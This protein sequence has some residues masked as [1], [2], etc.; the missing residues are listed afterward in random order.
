MG[1]AD[2]GLNFRRFCKKNKRIIIFSIIVLAVII[3]LNKLSLQKMNMP[4]IEFTYKPH[5]STMDN[6]SKVPSR[7]QKSIE[8]LV[9]EYVKNC[10]DRNYEKAFN[11][12]SEDCRNIH[13]NNNPNDFIKY[14]S[15]KM[16]TNK[17]YVIQNYSNVKIGN[18]TVYVYEI[19]YTEDLLATGLNGK[20]FYFTSEKLTFYKDNF[21]NVLMGVGGYIYNTEIKNIF[22]NEYLKIDIIKKIVNYDS[23]KYEIK[24]TNRSEKNIV[25]SS[26]LDNSEIVLELS[27]EAREKSEEKAIVLGPKESRT[28]YISFTKYV[29]D[30]DLS[31]NLNFNNIKVIE[32][33]LELSQDEESLEKVLNKAIAQF[34]VTIPVKE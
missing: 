19:R 10:N 18:N 6:N 4:E 1:I 20:D 9:K 5:V 15:K 30:G 12:L 8:N 16:P 32:Q 11:L 27:Q 31:V 21:D 28:E 7:M 3:G 2:W 14:V 24:F 22:E 34:N 23:E 17:K 25:I 29:D 26:G 13:F 33:D